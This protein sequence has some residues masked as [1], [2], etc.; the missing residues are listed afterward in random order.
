MAQVPAESGVDAFTVWERLDA[1]KIL[2]RIM[3]LSE[4]R[5]GVV[6]HD[7]GESG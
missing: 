2:H 1:G 6:Q 4:G 7:R 5:V 3:G